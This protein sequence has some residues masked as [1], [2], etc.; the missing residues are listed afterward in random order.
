MALTH[1]C[2]LFL[3]LFVAPDLENLVLFCNRHM[4]WSPD[5]TKHL[6]EPVLRQESG[7]IQTRIDSFMRY[8]DKIKFADV[9][10]KRLREVLGIKENG[11]KANDDGDEES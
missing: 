5:E 9:R 11:G 2:V 10:S 7:M 6:L 1:S 8:E 3:V 4:G